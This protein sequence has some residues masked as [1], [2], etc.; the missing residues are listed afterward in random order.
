MTIED[1]GT[2]TEFESVPRERDLFVALVQ[3]GDGWDWEIGPK[4]A[5]RDE[6]VEL[7]VRYGG[8]TRARIYKVLVPITGA[9]P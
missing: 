8:V 5:S 3:Y 4:G 6:V 2:L 7:I 1:G 9:Q